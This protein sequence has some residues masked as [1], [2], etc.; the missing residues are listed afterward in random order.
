MP[1]KVVHVTKIDSEGASLEEAKRVSMQLKV[2]ED[3]I[4][5]LT[6]G[7]K[8]FMEHLSIDLIKTLMPQEE[9]PF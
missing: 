4:K 1:T 3:D 8:D 2:E 9:S 7:A 5:V 6:V